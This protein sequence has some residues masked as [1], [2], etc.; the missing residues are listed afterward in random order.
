MKVGMLD[1]VDQHGLQ[2]SGPKANI[3]SPQVIATAPS[4]AVQSDESTLFHVMSRDPVM[5]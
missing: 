4:V 1:N 2:N 5:E 3:D